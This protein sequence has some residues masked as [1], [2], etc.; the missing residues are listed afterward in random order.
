MQKKTIKQQ[1][2]WIFE[3]WRLYRGTIP[4]LLLL[5]L[6][7]AVITV[8]YPLLVKEIIEGVESSAASEFFLWWTAILLL[9]G[10]VHTLV[11][12][13]MQLLRTRL[14][15]SFEYGV[16]QR[17]FEYLMRLGHSFFTRFRTGDVVTRLMDDVSDKLAWYMCSGIFRVIEALA[18]IVFCITAM[19][20][21]NAELTLYAAGPLPILILIFVFTADHLH[22]RYDTVQ[23]S[24]SHLNESL[25]T[26]FSG[27]RVV[28]AFTAESMQSEIVGR[29]IEEN[30][31]A[32]IR[33]VRWQTI[34][35]TL[36]GNIW[37][38]GIIG[39]LLVGGTMAVAGEVT[40]GELVAFDAYVL[41][42][43]WPMF[44][45]GQFLVRG[46]L[47]A[48]CI[49]RLAEIENAQPDV[50]DARQTAIVAR[51]PHVAAPPDYERPP[52]REDSLSIRFESVDYRFEEAERLALDD[53]S[54]EASAGK[55]TALVGE[56]GSGKS[57]VLAMIAR[58]FDPANGIVVV[59]DRDIRAWPL[60][61][62][63]QSIGYVPQEALLLSGSLRENI[64]FGREWVGDAD[65]EMA[66]E[67][68]QLRRDLAE[69]P[70]G[71]ETI[72]GS[73][74]VRLSGGQKQRV[75]L[76]RALA[77]RPSILLLDDC[78]ASLDAAT[79]EAVWRN[80]TE[81]I[82]GCTTLLVTHRPAT[83][84]RAHRIVVLDEGQVC[85]TGSFAELNTHDTLFHQL[86][87]QWKLRERIES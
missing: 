83:L 43:V 20:W 70:E 82:P 38:L 59:G 52:R 42:L 3:H 15:L 41:M 7:N 78:T 12:L 68:A 45:I 34:I 75:A 55:L 8:I 26:C 25:E 13:F 61:E 50:P 2:I 14:N 32:E 67:L 87:V 39:V 24:I 22:R 37:Q 6:L 86:Y 17:G 71:L 9:L 28:K 1:I 51:Q 27:I 63:R 80:L 54:F 62:L 84:A 36:W 60:V 40:L 57:T 48:V 30:R 69:W 29:A 5:T 44:D 10:A 77:G 53:V 23:Q 85:E 73:R 47:S 76:A 16:R 65:M 66:L 56:T 81:E 58:L 19:I 18:I 33:A 21:I 11:Y 46:K 64:R 35:D 72:V 79:E 31:Q 49:D 74:G 4:L